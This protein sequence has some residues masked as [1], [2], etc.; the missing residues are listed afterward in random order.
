MGATLIF[1]GGIKISDAGGANPITYTDVEIDGRELNNEANTAL[2]DDG[3]IDLNRFEGGMTARIRDLDVL[4]DTRVTF[5]AGTKRAKARIELISTVT[6]GSVR[7][8]NVKIVGTRDVSGDVE[9][10]VIQVGKHG[11]A[12]TFTMF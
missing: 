2:V 11:T 6:N 8:D 7:F 1:S 5:D 10:V 4:T 3:Q 12:A 9:V